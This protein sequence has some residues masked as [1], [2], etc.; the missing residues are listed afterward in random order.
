M[1]KKLT[2]AMALTLG[3][4]ASGAMAAGKTGEVTDYDFSFEGPFGT[5][6][7]QQLQR[8]LKV[9]TESCA[10]CHGM[11]FVPIRTLGDEGGPNLPD[12]QVR[13]Y[14]AM[15]EVYDESIRDFRT[16]TPTDHFP[17]S[18][19]ENAPDLS[20]MAK[21]RAGFS[22]PYGSG[23]N[24]LVRG[25]GGPEYIASLLNGYTG[26]I[27]EE[28][29]AVLYENK[30]FPGGWISMAPP[31]EDGWIEFDDGHANDLESMSKDV[32]AFLMWTAEPKM[33]AR[34]QAGLTGVLFLTVL[35]VL[36]YLTNKR[37]WAPIKARAKQR[38]D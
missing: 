34:K 4:A 11:K 1:L 8:G 33:M 36:L 21:A 29:G 30:A 31:L 27:R 3:L 13:A 20:L 14:A 12:D 23:I 38:K 16:A 6:D 18:N 17:E 15:L 24:Q 37:L 35:A 26:E 19:L 7:Q 2:I 22:G 28:A 9:Y 32:A 5:F 10:A 25:M